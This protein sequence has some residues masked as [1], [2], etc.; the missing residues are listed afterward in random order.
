MVPLLASE[1]ASVDR[2][3]ASAL[4]TGQGARLWAL[5]VWCLAMDGTEPVRT[6]L[7]AS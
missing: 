1:P 4:P 3:T 2:K 6:E 5:A 7:T